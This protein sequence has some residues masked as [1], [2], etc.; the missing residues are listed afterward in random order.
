MAGVLT[1]N[2]PRMGKYVD[3]KQLHR[4]GLDE[5]TFLEHRQRRVNQSCTLWVGNLS[6][7]TTEEQIE[8][9]F[10]PVGRIV[11]IAMG[12]NSKDHTPCGFA[13]IQYETHAEAADAIQMLNKSRLDD[14]KI[15]VQWDDQ[16]IVGSSVDQAVLSQR[17]WGRGIDGGQVVDVVKQGFDPGRGGVGFLR[18][19][20]AGVP[21][22]VVEDALVRYTW[23]PPPA[24]PSAGGQQPLRKFPVKTARR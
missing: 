9:V 13:F 18:R 16:P 22:G 7:Y 17:L 8:A 1:D 4:S 3:R 19:E 12:L 10:G 2:T 15:T 14:R 21:K 23:V 5:A 20:A 24:G 6:F 11:G